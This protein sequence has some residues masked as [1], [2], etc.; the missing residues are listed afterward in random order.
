MMKSTLHLLALIAPVLVAGGII[1]ASSLAANAEIDSINY[2]LLKSSTSQDNANGG[3]ASTTVVTTG[4]ASSRQ[5]TAAMTV[6]GIY[7]TAISANNPTKLDEIIKLIEETE[8]NAVVID[9][10]DYSGYVLYDSQVSN[11]NRWH[12]KKIILHNLASIVQKLHEHKIYTIARQTVFQDPLLAVKQPAWAIK[13]TTGELWHDKKGLAWVDPTREAV[14]KYN[15]SIAKEAIT[16]GFDELNFDYVRFP[17]DGN[18]KA[19]KYSSTDPRYVT[20]GRFY[21]Y[22]HTALADQPA[23]ISIDMFG[24]VMEAQGKNDLGIGQRL[25]DA[26][27]AVDYIS[28][29]MY[30]S[31]YAHGYAG[32]N[33]PAD[34]PAE[35]LERGLKLAA[36]HFEASQTKVR[37]WIQAFN[38]GAEYDA[39]KIRAQIAVVEK[40]TSAGWLM[41][42]SHNRYSRAGLK[43]K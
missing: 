6:K 9:I 36:P 25:V 4:A 20:M 28:P 31:H 32:F 1:M 21:H 41:W 11:V 38:L 17:S 22:L 30:P 42:N 2:Q 16:L 37:P 12:T 40:Y 8:L 24:L 13:D 39:A 23:W 15:V 43:N 18:L 29:M 34:H 3:S 5:K 10:K 35:V 33:N 27:D 14:W 7:L 19:V 26:L